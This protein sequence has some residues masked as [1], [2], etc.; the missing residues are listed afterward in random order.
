MCQAFAQSTHGLRASAR[1]V[2]HFDPASTVDDMVADPFVEPSE[3]GHLG[4]DSG[5]HAPR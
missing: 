2:Q 1:F 5:R 3:Q 4:T